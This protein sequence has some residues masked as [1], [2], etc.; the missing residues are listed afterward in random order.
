MKN[1]KSSLM[2]FLTLL[3]IVQLACNIPSNSAT[4]DTFATLNGLYTASAQTVEAAGT[5]GITVTPGLPLPTG[6]LVA[7]TVGAN[8]PSFASPVPVS[9]CD[10]AAFLTDVTYPDGSLVTRNS[11][12]VKIWRIKNVGTC[13]WTPSYSLV[14]SGG[15]AMSGPAVV[16][17]SA[18]VNPGQ[19]IELPVTLTSPNTDG[20]YRGYWKLRSPSG[21]L[22]G[23][24]PQADTAFWVDIR[25][26]GPA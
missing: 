17:V 20:H 18:N 2:M 1:K 16:S 12:F 9:K 11:T 26:T 5:L 7:P 22:F 4:P 19:Y 10:A 3:L 23:I 6:S 14:F 24:G 8:T 25:V 15:D 21:A 13:S